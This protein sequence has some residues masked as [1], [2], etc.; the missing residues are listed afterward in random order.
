MTGGGS[1]GAL[2][3]AWCPITTNPGRITTRVTNAQTSRILLQPAFDVSAT[4]LVFVNWYVGGTGETPNTNL[5]SVRAVLQPKGTTAA[6]ISGD[7]GYRYTFGGR[8]I[9]VCPRGGVL[10]TDPLPIG[11]AAGSTWFVKAYGSIAL[12]AAPSAPT[13]SAGGTGGALS[14]GTYGVA[15]TIVYPHGI[16]SA[17]SPST[18][19]AVT[20]GQVITVTA[21]SAVA[22][23]IG[24]RVWIT[25]VSGSLTG[26]HY[27]SSA[28]IMAFGSN[29]VLNTG[30][31]GSAAQG[32]EGADP[33]GALYLPA[34]GDVNGGTTVGG[35]NDGEGWVSLYDYTSEG[36][37]TPHRAAASIFMPA[38]V[39]G[40]SDAGRRRSV[41][42]I[43]D[44]ICS[45]TADSAF[46]GSTR[47]G[48]QMRAAMGQISQIAYDPNV[49]PQIGTFWLGTGSEQA[50]QFAANSGF[51]R[52]VVASQTST[53]W[54]NYGTNDTS[55]GSA[56]LAGS[57]YTI[58]KRFIDQGKTFAQSDIIAKT[59]STD[60][61]QTIA[62]QLNVGS[63]TEAVRQAI[64]NWIASNTGAV[65]I[66]NEVPFRGHGTTKGPSYDVF[67]GGDGSIV[68]FYTSHPF[69]T[70]TEVVKINGVTKTLTTDYTYNLSSTVN[71]VVYA[72]GVTFTAA[73][74]NGAVVTISYVKMAGM[75]SMLGGN[76]R[77]IPV[78]AAI[79]VDANGN[80]A[81][82]GTWTRVSDAPALGPRALTAIST[83]S[84][85]DSAQ[86][87]ATDQWRGYSAM[88]VTD[89]VTP[90]AVGQL[91][92]IGYN[93]ATVLTFGQTWTVTP[94][95]S[96]TYQI[97]KSYTQDGVHPTSFGHLALAQAA[98]MGNIA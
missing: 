45:G 13:A 41:A 73:P 28:G 23:A 4:R 68:T 37:A 78:S 86:S 56:A 29:A 88:I 95:T 17:C 60:G 63:L 77:F 10:F 89:S 53:I 46:T 62:N 32:I 6:E 97:L 24:Y 67:G 70:G 69:Q 2:I 55:F 66:N 92:C 75:R 26:T 5:Y 98:D 19:V 33:T 84:L 65:Q 18:S 36:R 39:L 90:T 21:P 91:R 38:G 34:G 8:D 50:A 64:N 42:L 25:Y 49:R 59:T 74:A 76:S 7:P 30:L 85:T 80:P 96:A 58:G 9:G 14:T 57:I 12:P 54:S 87:W 20:V 40:L 11:L 1:G 22:G 52:S 31:T 27:D 83:F 82:N 15:T 43:G 48:F 51:K 72:T 3:P 35:S 71:G 16:E 79:S 44:S 94:S 81:M 61:W 93:T 47:G